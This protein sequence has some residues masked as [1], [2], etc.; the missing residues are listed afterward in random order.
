MRATSAC[1]GCTPNRVITG[2]VDSDGGVW[3]PGTLGINSTNPPELVL[4]PA[5][6]AAA[7]QPPDRSMSGIRL[8]DVNIAERTA[9]DA[10][11]VAKKIAREQ[12]LQ[13]MRYSSRT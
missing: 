11:D 10:D 7:T 3:E 9:T 2:A 5:Q 4:N 8:G 6:Y 1:G 12:R 13:M